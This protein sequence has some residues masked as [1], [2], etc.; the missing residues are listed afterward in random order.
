MEIK[1]W[2]GSVQLTSKAD[3]VGNSED[4]SVWNESERGV[5]SGKVALVSSHS[6][7]DEQIRARNKHNRKTANA[8]ILCLIVYA[9]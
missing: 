4:G 1:Q 6:E 8:N 3:F 2:L 5:L 9:T 7:C